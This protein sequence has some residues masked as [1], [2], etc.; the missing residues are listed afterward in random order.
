MTFRSTRALGA[1][2]LGLTLTAA[3][4]NAAAPAATDPVAASPAAS[5]AG[6]G[7]STEATGSLPSSVLADT[8]ADATDEQWDASSEVAIALRD[9]GT[10]GGDGTAVDG[11]LL[12]ITAAGTYRISGTLSDGQIIVDTGDEGIVRLILDGV[13]VASATSA[14]LWVANAD[15]VVVILA[16]GSQN[17][18]TDPTDYQY[19]SADV[20]EPNAALFSASDLTIAGGT[21]AVTAADDGIRGKD[22]L[23]VTGGSLTVTAGSTSL[24]TAA[25]TWSS[26]TSWSTWAWSRSRPP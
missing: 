22:Y 19:A 23:V 26:P 14:P 21:I 12:T 25:R 5:V 3:C 13:T 17:T 18:L 2:L 4:G 1:M 7:T 15:E 20:D 8:H 24:A 6:G 16:D 10:T 9:G 11:D